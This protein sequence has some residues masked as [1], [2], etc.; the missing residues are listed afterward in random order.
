MGDQGKS[1]HSQ[2]GP[3]GSSS[4]LHQLWEGWEWGLGGVVIRVSAGRAG[5]S[6]SPLGVGHEQLHEL[7]RFSI[8]GY[9]LRL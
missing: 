9:L 7:Q 1:A 6:I 5:A 3:A 8:A 4:G 2:L